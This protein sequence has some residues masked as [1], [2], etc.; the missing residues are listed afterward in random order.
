MTAHLPRFTLNPLARGWLRAGDDEPGSGDG[1]DTWL[2]RRMAHGRI[3]DVGGVLVDEAVLE[4]RFACVPERCAPAKGRGPA[5]SCCADVAVPLTNA[6][7][8]RLMAVRRP[9][10]AWLAAHEPRLAG[11]PVVD[12]EDATL[13]RPGGRCALSHLHARRGL[14]CHLHAFARAFGTDRRLLQPLSCQLFPLILVDVGDGRIALT[15][16]GRATHRLVAAWPAD[17]YPCLADP[18]LPLIWRSLRGD[19]DW[20]FGRGFAR[21]LSSTASSRRR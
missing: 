5:R 9:L 11:S 21:A 7:R 17:R 19:L 12:A 14:R 13:A 6:E 3:A 8:R 18:G 16:V 4:Q 2:L 20:V 10:G 1:W 15:V